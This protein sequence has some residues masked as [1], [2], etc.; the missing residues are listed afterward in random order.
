MPL[1]RGEKIGAWGLTESTSG[2][3]AAGDAH[4]GGARRRLL[5]AQRIEDVHDARP[6]RPCD[7]RDGG[8]RS[9]RRHQRHLRLHRRTRDAGDGAGQEGRQARD[10]RQRHERGAVRELPRSPPISCSARK[11]RASSTRCRC[12]TP[13]RI[14]IAALAVGLAQ[15]AYEAAL[16]YARERRAFGKPIAQ[17]PGDPV[18]AGGRRDEDRGGAAADLPRGVP[19]G[20]RRAGRR[21]SRPW[22]SCTPSEIAVRVADDCVQIHGGYG[23]VKDYPAEKY[24][25]D[26]KL[27]TIGEGTSEIQRLVIARQLLCRS[28]ERFAD[29]AVAERRAAPGDRAR[30]DR[31]RHLARSKTKTRRA[32]TWSARSSAA[33]AAPISSASPARRA[34]ARARWS[35]G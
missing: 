14:G 22:R 5:G 21:S 4:D 8:D 25:R 17:L 10:A 35:I 24:F 28:H 33:P 2:S 9:R 32:P 26:V 20:P 16:S 11:A 7:G 34:P 19:E 3:D 29:D 18:E 27:T 12:S 6:R 30:R 13:G 31:P 15:G 23:F 1:A